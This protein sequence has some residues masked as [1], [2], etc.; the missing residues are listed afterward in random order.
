MLLFLLLLC[1]I[2]SLGPRGLLHNLTILGRNLVTGVIIA[3]TPPYMQL[4]IDAPTR[5]RFFLVH[6][7]RVSQETH[8]VTVLA[9]TSCF[10]WGSHKQKQYQER[11]SLRIWGVQRRALQVSQPGY[12]ALTWHHEHEP[13]E[14]QRWPRERVAEWSALTNARHAHCAPRQLGTT[15]N[16]RYD[17]PWDWL[18][19]ACQLAREHWGTCGKGFCSKEGPHYCMER[20]A[21]NPLGRDQ[22]QIVLGNRLEAVIGQTTI[23]LIHE[24]GNHLR[25]PYPSCTVLLSG[26]YVMRESWARGFFASKKGMIRICPM[27]VHTRNLRQKA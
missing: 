8:L 4:P 24:F 6:E 25:I 1:C 7:W 9:P 23:N 14:P 21:R 3:R 5:A 2:S 10:L 17:V 15:A 19:D 11:T 16:Q 18:W 26:G 12:S 13:Q 27:D 22:V 20:S